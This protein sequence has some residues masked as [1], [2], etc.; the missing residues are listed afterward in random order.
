MLETCKIWSD[1]AK[2]HFSSLFQH[3]IKEASEELHE[4]RQA[5]GSPEI[6]CKRKKKLHPFRNKS[7]SDQ[8]SISHMSSHLV[9]KGLSKRIQR[10][11][12]YFR[13]N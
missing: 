11:G 2:T 1:E 3:R 4:S 8:P 5:T 13:S 12:A 7:T 10:E 6:K 9:M